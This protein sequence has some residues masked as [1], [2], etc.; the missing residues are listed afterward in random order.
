MRLAATNA[1]KRPRVYTAHAPREG[2]LA[3]LRHS[4]GVIEIVV[5][6]TTLVDVRPIGLV[7]A[8]LLR[9]V[10]A[11]I[12][13]AGLERFALLAS[14]DGTPVAIRYAAEHPELV[15]HLV[16]GDAWA[17]YSDFLGT[18][19][20]GAETALLSSCCTWNKSGE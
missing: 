7:P 19:A 2:V 4:G 6:P 9:D 18:A 1:E 10:D 20:I 17:K 15:S 12:T 11:V 8:T 3:V 16:L 13:G 14:W 5:D